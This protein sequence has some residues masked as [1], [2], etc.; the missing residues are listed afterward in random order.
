MS[1]RAIQEREEMESR[2]GKMLRSQDPRL[3]FSVVSARMQRYAT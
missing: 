3:L 2:V 1:D